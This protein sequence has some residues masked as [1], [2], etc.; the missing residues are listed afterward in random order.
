MIDIKSKTNY[1]K[2]I[3]I[4]ALTGLLLLGIS[5]A[6][7]VVSSFE[8]ENAS[9]SGNGTIVNDTDASTGK[10]I[11]FGE[12]A[13]IVPDIIWQTGMESGLGDWTGF[14]PSGVAWEE[15]TQAQ[16]HSGSNALALHA[17]ASDGTSSGIRA[18]L[19]DRI[20][21]NDPD[22]LPPDGYYS[23]WYYIPQKLDPKN[24]IY[25]WKQAYLHCL[26][27]NTTSTDCTKQTR[28]LLFS[29]R[30]MWDSTTGDHKLDLRG[31]IDQT[32]GKWSGSAGADSTIA[33]SGANLRMRLNT[34]H[35]LECRYVWS[36]GKTGRI[37]CWLDGQLWA[38][39]N[40]I[41]TQIN[42]TQT[43]DQLNPGE[44]T[45]ISKPRQWTVNNYMTEGD[46]LWNP[47]KTVIYIDDAAI[48]I[49][50]RVGP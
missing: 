50:G 14:S 15:L 45:Y 36:E 28:R 39:V 10:Y 19:N 48:S 41:Y 44:K 43:S 16:V 49:G 42:L 6:K 26:A 33:V 38:D 35:H 20:Y 2:V 46:G 18:T 29:I 1:L 8:A 7:A 27:D 3:S 34:W 24:N 47:L 21:G 13:S 40:N 11:K 17:D 25:Q 23:A 31:R 4:F 22:N 12:T 9:V 37:Q 30:A 5:N 32:T